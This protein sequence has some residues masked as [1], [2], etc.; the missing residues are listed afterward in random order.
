MEDG[1]HQ[2]AIESCPRVDGGY[3]YSRR[4]HQGA[5]SCVSGCRWIEL[6]AAIRI[7]M[8]TKD[9]LSLTPGND[10]RFESARRRFDVRFSYP[11]C[12]PDASISA[13]RRTS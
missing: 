8:E 5:E 12:T 2:G 11:C 3:N 4:I 10:G 9:R 1:L 7:R 6:R 13:A